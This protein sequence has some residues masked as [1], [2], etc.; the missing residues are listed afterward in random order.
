M[1][2]VAR[3]PGRLSAP[4]LKYLRLSGGENAGPWSSVEPL[5][6]VLQ[7]NALRSEAVQRAPL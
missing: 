1:R 5:H 6:Q 4:H 7:L 2:C 3:R